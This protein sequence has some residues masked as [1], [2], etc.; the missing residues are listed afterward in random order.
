M[1]SLSADVLT[2]LAASEV[3]LVTLVRIVFPGT[4]IALNSS[5]WH[6]PHGGTTYQGA[7]GLGA[8][9]AIVD[10]PG[11]LPGIQLELQNVDSA[12]ISLAL[13]DADQVQG[14]AVT[15]STAILNRTTYAV[16]HVETDWTG[17]ADTMAITEDGERGAIT[18]TCESK[19]VDLLKGNPLTYSDA[20]QQS[21]V[22]GD[23]IF[24]YIA[25]QADKPVVWPTRDHYFR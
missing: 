9:A 6:I 2:A 18:L 25:Q 3:V 1:K 23:R 4:T 8:V 11:E 13:D 15:I 24:E 5:T 12:H 14:S 17:T 20:D 22:P 16:L 10:K 21:L 7:A 19:G